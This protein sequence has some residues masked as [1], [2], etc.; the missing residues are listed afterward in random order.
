MV[1]TSPLI[2]KSSSPCD[3]PL[4]TVPRATIT[5]CITVTF[6]FHGFFRPL[7]RCRHLSFF[8]FPSLIYIINIIFL[9]FA[10]FSHCCWLVDFYRSLSDNK[11][12]Q[13]SRNLLS[14]LADLNVADLS[15]DFQDLQF[16][17]QFF[18]DG[19]KLLLLLLSSSVLLLLL[20]ESFSHQPSWWFLTWARVIASL[21]KSPGLFSWLWPIIIMLLFGWSFS[22]F[23]NPLGIVPSAQITTGITVTFMFHSFFF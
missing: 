11:S 20:F 12:S 2:S 18:R 15:S 21:H 9:H 8:C 3:K 16:F 7:A 1:S 10:S 5:I 23:I 13:I 17:F 22:P 6:I 14:I 19:F 4:V